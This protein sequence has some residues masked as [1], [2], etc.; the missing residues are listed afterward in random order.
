MIR[1]ENITIAFDRILL[2]NASIS[3]PDGKLTVIKGKSGSGKSSLLYLIGF[4]EKN[5]DLIYYF[6]DRQINTR[7]E[8]LVSEIRKN[9]IGYVFQDSSLIEHL[10]V[11]ENLCLYGSMIGLTLSEEDAKHLLCQVSLQDKLNQSVVTLSGGEKQRLAIACALIK[12]PELLILDEPTSALDKKNAQMI[13]AILKDLAL[14]GMAILLSSHDEDV[15]A[16]CDEVYEFSSQQLVHRV[17][18]LENEK[19]FNLEKK[20]FPLHFYTDYIKKYFKSQKATYLILFLFLSVIVSLICSLN[21]IGNAFEN[22]QLALLDNIAN[23]EILLTSQQDEYGDAIYDIEAQEI[24]EAVIENI[25]HSPYCQAVYPYTQG[26]TSSLTISNE[27]KEVFC[28]I[29]PYTL[30]MKLENQTMLSSDVSNGIYISYDL[31]AYLG[32]ENCEEITLSL[33]CNLTETKTM[34]LNNLVLSGILEEGK[35]NYYSQ[36]KN[37]IYVPYEIMPKIEITNAL[38]VYANHFDEIE[39]LLTYIQKLDPT[40]GVFNVAFR[41]RYLEETLQNIHTLT[42]FIFLMSIGISVILI[43]MIYSRQIMNR[44]K[45]M[46]LLKVNGLNKQDIVKLILVEMLLQIGIITVL[47]VIEISGVSFFIEK[48]MLL[49]MET[50]LVVMLIKCFTI[51][52]LFI[53]PPSMIASFYFQKDSVAKILRN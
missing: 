49:K 43:V 19:S 48:M 7:N 32:I 17:N 40:L 18:S 12:Q 37:V 33:I 9:K 31:G 45:E 6:H 13:M 38:L 21:A 3:I 22:Y 35:I 11:Y 50:N 44:R 20:N 25:I 42:P 23:C 34:E 29:Q 41:G 15:I 24:N 51:T 46:C 8:K 2:E 28:F 1:I 39:P 14:K 26:Y 52:S 47:S 16:Q 4:L 36:E 27:T 53:I 5:N 30:E 10:N